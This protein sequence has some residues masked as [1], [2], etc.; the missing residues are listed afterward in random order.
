MKLSSLIVFVLLL[1]CQ[2]AF[3]QSQGDVFRAKNDVKV[4]GYNGAEKTLAWAGGVNSPQFAMGDLNNDNMDDLV[5]FEREY[6]ARTFIAT[7]PQTFKYDIKYEASFNQHF[8]EDF[9]YIGGYLKLVD[10]NRDGIP[11]M[12]SRGYNG[13]GV[14][15]GY[16]E[17]N[18]LKFTFYKD[19]RYLTGGSGYV[20]AYVEPN[21]IPGA[22]DIDGDGDID[23]ISYFVLGSQI[24][25][26]K[27]C[28]VEDGLPQDSIKICVEDGCWSKTLQNYERKQ[29]L[30]VDC[31][32]AWRTCPKPGR[33]EGKTTHSGNTLCLIDIDGDGDL[34]HFNGNVSFPDIQFFKNGRIE[35]G[36]SRDSAVVQDTI[37]GANGKDMYM[38]IFPAAYA[39]DIDADGDE[40]LL[41]SPNEAN[42]ENYKSVS[43]Y[44]NT[45]S[46]SNPNYVYQSDTFLVDQMIDKGTGAYPVFYDY[47]KDG[48]K[49]LF[50][51]SDGYYQ[52]QT[53]THRSTI[54]YY[55]NTTDQDGISFKLITDDFLNLESLNIAGAALAIGDINND[56]LDDL[57]LGK[58]DGTFVYFKNNAG[59][60]SQQPD[61]VLEAD[62]LKDEVSSTVLDVGDFAA[63]FIYDMDKDGKND[64]IV[65][66]QIG[67]LYYYKNNSSQLNVIGLKEITKNLGGVKIFDS[68]KAFSYSAPYIGPMDNTGKDYLVVGTYWGQ[69]HR[70]D[71]FQSGTLPAQFTLVDSIYSLINERNRATPAFA[72][73]DNDANNLYELVIGNA[74]GGLHY[75]QQDF[76]V[77]INDNVK[78][79]DWKMMVFPNPANDHITVRWDKNG[80]EGE[81]VVVQLISVTGQKLIEKIVSANEEQVVLDVSTLSSGM[82]YCIGSTE[83]IRSVRPISIIK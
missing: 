65:G 26:Y 70:Y 48:L 66:N 15:P 50:V 22:A 10:Y 23:F 40:D 28:Q 17:N 21:D 8:H 29:E 41:F 57:V 73:L 14:Y 76:A 55:K 11:D 83:K 9:V 71:G 12:V 27:N 6:G 32:N 69:L 47:D 51:G 33:G 77:S 36:S 5:I 42:T 24:T 7:G 74:L 38:P 1:S 68:F 34:D 25:Y 30:G 59:S 18:V 3:S 62:P 44:K 78:F 16:Y 56:T 80:N 79:I 2:Q 61:W 43:F 81:Q 13:I 63:P 4:I 39:L 82:Y 37:W 58:S 60:P 45:G 52:D 64:L 54:S 53:G 75:Y 19:L 49:D 46:K 35:Y 31:G 20:N 72:N 67:D